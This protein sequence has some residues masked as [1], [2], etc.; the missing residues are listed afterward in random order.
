M[1]QPLQ[2]LETKKA[3]TPMK[4]VL[5]IFAWGFWGAVLGLMVLMTPVMEA[6]RRRKAERERVVRPYLGDWMI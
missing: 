3:C 6:R 1:G 2:A 4:E 5:P